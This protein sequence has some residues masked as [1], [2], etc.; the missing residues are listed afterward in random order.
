MLMMWRSIIL[1]NTNKDSNNITA[2]HR[3]GFFMGKRFLYRAYAM[4]GEVLGGHAVGRVVCV[5]GWC[6]GGC[7]GVVV[8]SNVYC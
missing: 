6:V 1:D 7:V 2:P 3:R 8:S 4:A 5:E